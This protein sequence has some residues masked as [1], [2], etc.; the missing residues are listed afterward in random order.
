MATRR[1][2]QK[3]R[4]SFGNGRLVPDGE[5]DE[6]EKGEIEGEKREGEG[7]GEEKEKEH[8]NCL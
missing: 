6:E 7:E 1:A 5:E 8:L 3:K 2:R 4:P